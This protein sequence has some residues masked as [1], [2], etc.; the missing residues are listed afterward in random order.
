M[1]AELPKGCAGCPR[2]VTASKQGT[3]TSSSDAATTPMVS[4]S[5]SPG[6]ALSD[7][8]PSD[9]GKMI[10]TEEA[11]A[12]SHVSDPLACSF[13]CPRLVNAS[14]Q[15]TTT[16]LS[17][18]GTTPMASP[19]PSPGQA[20]SDA[21][22]SDASKIV[23]E[24]GPAT[25]G[26]HNVAVVAGCTDST[27]TNFDPAATSDD[28]TCIAAQPGCMAPTALNYDSTATVNEGCTYS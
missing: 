9:A 17:D 11:Q 22:P 3:T 12:T 18:A 13:P 1:P 10:I 15:G 27:A 26:V 8:S 24:N 23:T 19:S 6:Q 4:P 20:I 16:S 14:K 21:S 2:L 5:P 28:G 25:P 7:A